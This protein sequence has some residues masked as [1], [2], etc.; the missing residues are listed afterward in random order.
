[1]SQPQSQSKR[2]VWQAQPR[3]ETFLQMLLDPQGPDE[4]LYGGAAGG[5]KTDALLIACITY[6]RLYPGVWTL[7][8]RRTFPELEQKPIPRSKQLIP[9]KWATYNETKHRWQ[10]ANGSVL[11]FGS[12][13]RSGDEI[14]YQSAEFALI[15]FDELTHFQEGQYLYLLSRNRTTDPRVRPK[16]AGGTNPGGPGHGWVKR[17]WIDPAPPE[18]IWAAP[19]TVE[20]AALG[21]TPRRRCFVPA[22]LEDNQ[23]LMQADPGY[24]ARLMELPEHTRKAL[25]DGDWNIFAGQVFTEWRYA[26][27]VIEPFAIPPGWRRWRSL[28]WGYAKPFAV[29]WFAKDPAGMTVVYRELYGCVPGE[30]DTGVRL[31]AEEVGRRIAEVER[32]AGEVVHLGYADPAC[33]SK[34]GHEGPTIAES[35]A[36]GG[37]VFQKADNDRMQGLAKVHEMLR[38][39]KGGVPDL[40]VFSTCT[41]LIRTLP[42]LPHDETH[43]EDVDTDAEDHLYDALRYGLLS[44]VAPKRTREPKAVEHDPYTGY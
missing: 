27:H 21:I 12:L 14:R 18:T 11:Q 24:L 8:L 30:P 43:P 9:A 22:K 41:E 42:E 2:R 19:Q 34:A 15:V 28:D 26:I 39:R 38:V 32:R 40:V 3:Q 44:R 37:A 16:M 10:F 29:L 35:L 31:D 36:K 6:C 5:G 33:W 13:D 7:F 17:R 4:I 20:E 25:M 1:M 23:I